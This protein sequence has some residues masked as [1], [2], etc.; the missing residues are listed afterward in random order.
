M[1]DTLVVNIVGILTVDPKHEDD[2]LLFDIVV[3]FARFPGQ[4]FLEGFAGRL[5]IEE[6]V[7][8]EKDAVAGEFAGADFAVVADAEF[9]DGFGLVAVEGGVVVGLESMKFQQE[10]LRLRS[11]SYGT[12]CK[13]GEEEVL[14]IG[15]NILIFTIRP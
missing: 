14:K 3:L 7:A 12:S 11:L 6:A 10:K 13:G 4:A 9:D 8:G 1:L 2:I 5:H 15:G